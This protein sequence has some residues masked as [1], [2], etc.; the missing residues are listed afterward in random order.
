MAIHYW[1]EDDIVVGKPINSQVVIN[2][3]V[4]LTEEEKEQA[5]KNALQRAENEAFSRMMKPKRK[6]TIKHSESTN[7]LSLF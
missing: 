7:Q 3:V 2:H 5:R 1:D 4:E 6:L